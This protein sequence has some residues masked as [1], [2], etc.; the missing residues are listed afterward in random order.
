M[1]LQECEACREMIGDDQRACPRCGHR[2]PNFATSDRTGKVLA[3][4]GVH[5]A[6]VI[7][8]FFLGVIS[9]KPDP[10]IGRRLVILIVLAAAALIATSFRER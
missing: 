1:P 4:L 2:N 8:L 10:H 6:P 9:S 7:I 5:A 3:R